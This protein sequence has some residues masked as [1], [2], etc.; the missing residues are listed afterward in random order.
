VLTKL[1]SYY[2]VFRYLRGM[3]CFCG[4]PFTPR[5]GAFGAG[6]PGHRQEINKTRKN[7]AARN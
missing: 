3:R 6:L 1:T 2:P 7:T 4:A 5:S